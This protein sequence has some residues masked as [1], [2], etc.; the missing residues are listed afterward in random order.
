MSRRDECGLLISGSVKPGFGGARLSHA[1][2]LQFDA[3]LSVA[4]VI[5]LS[6]TF[7]GGDL[8]LLP[9]LGETAVLFNAE[10]LVGLASRGRGE[11]LVPSARFV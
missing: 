2:S 5:W 10:D 6:R 11:K 3:V 9:R 8:A 4:L 1:L 7:R